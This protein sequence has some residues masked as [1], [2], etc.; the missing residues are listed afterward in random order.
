[1]DGAV[2]IWNLFNGECTHTLTGHTSLIGLLCTSP[3]YL[4]SGCADSTLRVWDPVTGALCH[5]L[6]EHSGAITAFQHDDHKVVSGADG[7]VKLWDIRTGKVIRD[8][9]SGLTGVWQVAYK[10]QRC[11]AAASRGGESF[12]QVWDFGNDDGGFWPG[13]AS[14]EK[15]KN[16]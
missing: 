15:T 14:D 13:G 12:L 10:G 7:H 2:R 4:V 5:T 11:I 1:M 6:T 8:L 3:S 9:S 16:H